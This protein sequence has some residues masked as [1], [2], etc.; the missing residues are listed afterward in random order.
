MP[1]HVF[2][3]LAAIDGLQIYAGMC[4][5]KN[6]ENLVCKPLPYHV[7]SGKV[8]YHFKKNVGHIH[9]GSGGLMQPPVTLYTNVSALQ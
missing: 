4:I 2:D 9:S 7:Y 1:D 5:G 3:I 8:D 6:T